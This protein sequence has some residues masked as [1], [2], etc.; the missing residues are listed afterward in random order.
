MIARYKPVGSNFVAESDRHV[1]E[2]HGDPAQQFSGLEILILCVMF[3]SNIYSKARCKVIE[4]ECHRL[5]IAFSSS[6]MN[7]HNMLLICCLVELFML[8]T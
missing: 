7:L 1:E 2:E 3:L 5:E 4:A 8:G 6:A